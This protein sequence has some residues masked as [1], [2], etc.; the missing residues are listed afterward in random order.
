[1]S[2]SVPDPIALFAAVDG[3]LLVCLIL[4]AALE[5]RQRNRKP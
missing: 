1:M 4:W 5:L 3:A 2:I